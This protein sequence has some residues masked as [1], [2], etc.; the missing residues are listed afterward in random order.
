MKVI[1]TVYFTVFLILINICGLFAQPSQPADA[2]PPL[3][4][5]G[6]PIDSYLLVLIIAAL[7]LGMVV[8]YKNKIKKASV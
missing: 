6:G 3:E 2:G 7:L 8:I 4:P 1:K 5:P